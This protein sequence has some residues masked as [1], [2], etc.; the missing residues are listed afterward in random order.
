M[1][2]APRDKL[3]CILNC[4]KVIGNL[5]HHA[6]ISSEDVPGADEFLPVLIY[7]T[8]KVR[9]NIYHYI[10]YLLKPYSYI[11][12][13]CMVPDI[14][15]LCST[16]KLV[17][18]VCFVFFMLI[19]AYSHKHWLWSM[20]M[21]DGKILKVCYDLGTRN[22]WNLSKFQKP[23]RTSW[24]DCLNELPIILYFGLVL[25]LLTPLTMGSFLKVVENVLQLHVGG[26]EPK[27]PSSYSK[28]SPR[29]IPNE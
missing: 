29:I 3:V 23:D 17:S 28:P 2:K 25:P 7:V 11:G 24:L 21:G 8:I 14:G 1:Y 6:S 26:F 4:C 18:S 9:L 13:N 15:Y 12:Y 16:L 10:I 22:M 27:H 20:D 19:V 5:L